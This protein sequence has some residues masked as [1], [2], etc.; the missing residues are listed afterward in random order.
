MATCREMAVS[1]EYADFIVNFVGSDPEI[2]EEFDTMCYQRI[3]SY[4]GVIYRPLERVG[5]LRI[6]DYAYNT[7]PA[8]YGLSEQDIR[9]RSSVT[10][11]ALEAA[12]IL[13]LA[14]QPALRLRGQGCLVAFV[15]TGINIEDEN[16]RYSNGDTRIIRLWDMN[17]ESGTPPLGIAYGSEYDEEAINELLKRNDLNNEENTVYPGR[18]ELGHGNILAGIAAGNQGAVPE[19]YIVVVKLKPAKQYLRDYHMIREG[20]PAYQE[21]DIMLG[22]NYIKDVAL[23][24]NMPVS[25]CVAVGTNSRSHDGRSALS[26]IIDRF[27]DASSMEVASVSGGSQGNKQLHASGSIENDDYVNVELRVDERQRGVTVNVWGRNPYVISVGIVSPT[28]EVIPRIPARIGQAD[29]YE[30]LFEGTTVTVEYD[31]AERDSGDELIIIRMNNPSPGIWRL[32]IYGGGR[33]NAY[34]PLSQFIY[35]NTYFL[36]PDPEITLTDPAYARQAI[37][38]VSYDPASETLYIGEGRGFARDGFVKP[39]IA[40]P[41]SVAV[42]AGAVSQFQNWSLL[43]SGG[44]VESSDIKSYLI[45]GAGRSDNMIYPNRQWGYGKLDIYNAFE[46]LRDS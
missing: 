30:L 6:S 40:S 20:V 28:G 13:R 45:R 3:S 27:S 25:L 15:D 38:S 16:F 41:M 22:I 31:L 44:E 10:E 36:S 9:V 26:Y 14:S 35:E 29:T 34:L 8:L 12:G 17:D 4:Y 43:F 24:L 21:N 18:D 32:Q 7:I 1:E 46:V 39:D 5:E 19:S 33:F 11:E 2:T 37:S 23:Q 42:L